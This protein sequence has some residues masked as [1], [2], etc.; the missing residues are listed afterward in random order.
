MTYG[1]IRIDGID[2]VDTRVSSLA[3]VLWV[4]HENKQDICDA[5]AVK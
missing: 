4:G 3:T 5:T 1:V 2:V